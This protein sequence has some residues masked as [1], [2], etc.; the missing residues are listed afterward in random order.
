MNETIKEINETIERI[1]RMATYTSDATKPGKQWFNNA[2][3]TYF[4]RCI[5]CGCQ[6]PL[7]SPS[8]FCSP[9]CKAE[10]LQVLDKSKQEENEFWQEKRQKNTELLKNISLTELEKELARRKGWECAYKK[11]CCLTG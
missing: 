2:S 3:K 6:F 9:K 1:K 10:I 7:H 5:N 4:K 8:E 11:K